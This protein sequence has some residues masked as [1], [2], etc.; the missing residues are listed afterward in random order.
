MSA[1]PGARLPPTLL[2]LSPGTLRD[3]ADVERLLQ[4]AAAARAAGLRGVLLR[5]PHLGER[6]FL[7]LA[8]RLRALL[9]GDG[10]WLGLHD[11]AHLVAAAGADAVH[12]GFRSLSPAELR[13][14]LPADVAVGLS[15]HAGDD[16]AAWGSADY[17]VH[18]PVFDTP[19]KRGL[20]EPIGTGGLAAAVARA[21]R[22][23]WA[24]GG[25]APEH[26]ERVRGAL[27]AGARGVAV[28]AAVL[29]REDPA[30]AV[31][32]LLALVGSRGRAEPS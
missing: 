16:V 7:E 19:S 25:L 15:T 26:P 29:A 27:E 1:G 32:A 18:G 13:S 14:W 30:P 20:L 3:A 10:G 6:P 17:L 21:P 28:L 4:R 5:E 2:A 9:A 24:L 23:V 31:R 12:V 22:P 11:R 8:R